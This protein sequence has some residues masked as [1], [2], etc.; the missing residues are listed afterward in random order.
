M[1]GMYWAGGMVPVTLPLMLIAPGALVARLNPFKSMVML[2]LPAF[3]A[4]NWACLASSKLRNAAAMSLGL[5]TKP[6]WFI[7]SIRRPTC[8]MASLRVL[9]CSCRDSANCWR[10]SATSLAS[11]L[12]STADLIEAILSSL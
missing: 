6:V 2:P 1:P 4:L 10:I 8:L 9:A 12:P 7:F 5:V 3:H 11:A